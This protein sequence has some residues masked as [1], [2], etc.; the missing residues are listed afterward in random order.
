MLDQGG[1][2]GRQING[3]FLPDEIY[4]KT[5]CNIFNKQ[6]VT[7][8]LCFIVKKY[9]I[10]S[11]YNNE[12]SYIT[13]TALCFVNFGPCSSPVCVLVLCALVARVPPAPVWG[14]GGDR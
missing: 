13:L 12:T 8:F 2:G 10:A 5:Y 6:D 1:L 9:Y 14:C 7:I 4:K 11:Q 3:S